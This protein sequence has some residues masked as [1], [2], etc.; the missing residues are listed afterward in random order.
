MRYHDH[1]IDHIEVF[2]DGAHECRATRSEVQSEVYKFG[3]LSARKAQRRRA[4]AL[5]TAADY[6]RVVDEQ[7]RLREENVD[8]SEW[9]V[10]PPNPEDDDEF[11]DASTMATAVEEFIGKGRVS[12]DPAA[13]EELTGLADDWDGDDSDS[14]DGVTDAWTSRLG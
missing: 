1:D 4:E 5:V 3:V 14:D 9:P 6:Q 11:A 8:E 10:L 13:R 2:V 7:A 12:E